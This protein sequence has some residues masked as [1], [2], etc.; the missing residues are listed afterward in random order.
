MSTGRADGAELR[1]PALRR[2]SVAHRPSPGPGVLIPEQ[3]TAFK[4]DGFVILPKFIAQDQLN[5]WVSRVQ[6]ACTPRSSLTPAADCRHVH[7]GPVMQR[8]TFWQ[9]I[10]ASPDDPESWPG[11]WDKYDPGAEPS[12]KGHPGL[13]M[14]DY[15][16]VVEIVDQLMGAHQ[17]RRGLRP[18]NPK[19]GE[20]QLWKEDDLLQAMWPEPERGG[21]WEPPAGGHVDGGNTSK[22]GWKG[23]FMLGAITCLEDTVAGGGCF[24]YWPRSHLAVHSFLKA[25]PEFINPNAYPRLGAPKRWTVSLPQG[26]LSSRESGWQRQAMLFFGTTG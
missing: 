19:F 12:Q 9:A 17:W 13:R 14:S 21:V 6:R 5:T 3:I 23:G 22:D 24:Y 15:P 18:P 25:K 2:L 1:P 7:T 16:P 26:I 8:S 11:D 10:G 4:H 20:T